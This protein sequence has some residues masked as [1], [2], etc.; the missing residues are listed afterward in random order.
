VRLRW[1]AVMIL[2]PL[3]LGQ[4]VA[5]AQGSSTTP[6]VSPSPSPSVRVPSP[7][8]Q[9]AVAVKSSAQVSAVENSDSVQM[10][11]VNCGWWG[12]CLLARMVLPSSMQVNAYQLWFENGSSTPVRIAKTALI[13]RGQRT[14]YQLTEPDLVLNEQN[15]VLPGNQITRLNLQVNRL[16]IPPDQYNG[17][18]YLM[19]K[20]S[21]E[22]LTLPLM[23]NVRTGPMLPIVALFFGVV[24]GRLLKYM[25][26]RG[27]PQS[28]KLKLINRLEADLNNLYPEDQKILANM[29]LSVRQLAFREELDKADVQISL[30]RGRLEVLQKLRRIQE[31]I[32]ADTTGNLE[33]FLTRVEQVRVFLSEAE[34]ELAKRELQDLLEDLSG[35]KGI[36]RGADLETD[37]GK[38]IQRLDAKEIIARKP[39][40]SLRGSRIRKGL[41]WLSGVSDELRAEA[42]LWVVRPMLSLGL[43]VGLALMGINELYVEKGASLGAK[44]LTDYWG[45]V[46]WG[47]SADV[48]SRSLSSLKEKQGA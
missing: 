1:A 27:G 12:D 39:S 36:A 9:P 42:T 20:D 46:L 38:A 5:F 8:V 28:E 33:Q 3:V 25:Q 15:R 23:I 19:L 14:G 30:I 10:D 13:T 2:V 31:R 21:R 48:A 16:G 45:L 7:P 29:L 22:R 34:D 6:T 4:S 18:L 35:M 37:V 41:I 43:L 11:L 17:K 32:A 40:E 26:E 24:L 47:L 44:P